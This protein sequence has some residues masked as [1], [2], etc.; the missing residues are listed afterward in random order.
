MLLQTIVSDFYDVVDLI[1]N[2]D[3]L[4]HLMTEFCGIAGIPF[5]ALTHHTDFSLNP[6]DAVH[7]HN[8]PPVF[9]RHYHQNGL[10]TRDPVHRAS[11]F[12]GAGFA[13]SS[14]D[15]LLNLTTAD[16][17]FLQEASNAGLGDGYTVPVHMPGEHTGS[18]S[19]AVATGIVFPRD[20]IPLVEALGRF[21]FEAARRLAGAP[22]I[23]VGSGGYLTDRE[24]EIVILLGRDKSEKEIAWILGITQVT[25]NDHLK[26]ARQRFGVHK[27]TALL[28]C[29][30][31]NGFITRAD[32]L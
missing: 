11:E 7:L 5:F 16:A 27:S 32:F 24:R 8:Y 21:A 19:F 18:C 10:M 31:V 6:K 1:D 20:R 22:S 25:V 9:A 29:G 13:W 2:S 3:Q 23:R 30:I 17:N 14:L 12:R 26:H 15:T 28:I 4:S